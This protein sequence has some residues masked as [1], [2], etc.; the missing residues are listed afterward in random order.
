MNT[1]TDNKNKKMGRGLGSLLGGNVD[2][3]QGAAFGL[4]SASAAPAPTTTPNQQTKNESVSPVSKSSPQVSTQVSASASMTASVA[5]PAKALAQVAPI[6]EVDPKSRIWNISI[7][8]LD[9]GAFQPRK[10]FDKQ[11]LQDLAQSIKE[12]GI[13]QP[14]AVRKKANGKF[15]IVAGERRWRA[16]QMA[17]LHEVPALIK[18]FDDQKT[19]ELAI[20]ENIQREDLNP[21]EEAESYFRLSNEF[22]LS[23]QQIADKVGKDRASVSN[24]IRLLSLPISILKMVSENVISVGHA[25]VLLSVPN[26]EKQLD[27]AK[28]IVE[29]SLSVRK[30]EKVIQ[31]AQK[32]APPKAELADGSV[33]QKLIAGLAEEVQ[34]LL[35]TKV[36]IDY[37]NSKGKISIH[38]YSDDELTQIIDRLKS[39]V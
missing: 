29:D 2:L 19:L 32:I 33:T 21:V 12:N 38:F 10:N 8:K 11:S 24:A 25:K 30:L 7:D 36:D 9:A 34:K 28:Q 4:T 39:N 23:Q 27:F 37:K 5:A 1:T 15:E 14:I 22:N 35:S 18:D 17:G 20:I 26:I 16:A 13:L 31:Q 3:S 6:A